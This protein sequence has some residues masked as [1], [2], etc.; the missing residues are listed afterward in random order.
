MLVL[1][2]AAPRIIGGLVDLYFFMGPTPEAVIRQYHQVVGAPLMPPY[3]TLGLHQSK[4]GYPNISVL[5]EVVANY[6]AAGL[7]LE[8]LWV[9]IEYMQSRFRSMTFDEGLCNDTLLSDF[10]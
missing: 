1:L 3:W 9:D 6:S 5:E 2:D 8:S 10:S 7:P 4:W